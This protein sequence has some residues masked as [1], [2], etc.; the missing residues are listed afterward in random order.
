[1]QPAR[2]FE[3]FR[4]QTLKENIGELITAAILEGKLRPDDR[5]NES[6]LAR[7]LQV[8]RAPIREALQQLEE[9]GLVVNIPR[10]GMFVVSLSEEELQ[11][12]NSL[13]IL[14][15]AEALRLC[16]DTLTQQ[17]E[18][19]LLQALER[20]ERKGMTAIEAARVDLEFHRCLW[21]TTGNEYLEKTLTSLTAPL[22]A[23]SI[24]TL[25]GA[26]TVRW[27]LDSHRPLIEFVRRKTGTLSAEHVMAEHLSHAWKKPSRYAS[28]ELLKR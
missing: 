20:M 3:P 18:K 1:M 26:A 10:R 25:P 23:Y 17:T 15:E 11:K 14:L 22:F 21:Q 5:L 13:R 7:D 27:I 24:V 12:I 19:K 4:T 6:A 2:L 28:Q 8:S 9:Q 16:R